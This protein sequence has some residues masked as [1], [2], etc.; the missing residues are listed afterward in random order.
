MKTNVEGLVVRVT[1]KEIWVQT[2]GGMV[3]CLLRGRFRQKGRDF[4][5][6]AGDRVEVAPPVSPGSPGAIEAVLPRRS[7]L[8]R[9]TGGRNAEERIIVANIDV[10]FVIE[11]IRSPD[12]SY[13][14]L[15]RVIVS[16]ENGH[17]DARICIN[18]IDLVDDR[19]DV[20]DVTT[21]YEPLGY[22]VVQTSAE[23]GEG[24][25]A[26]EDL[27]EGGIYAFVGRSGVGKSSLLNRIEPDLKLRVGTVAEKTGRGHH[28]TTYS[29]LFP[30]KGGYVADTPGMQTF[31]YPGTSTQ[32]LSEC[33]P[34]LRLR[35]DACRFQPCTHSHE[36]DCVVKEALEQGSI[37]P[38]R[39]QSY[40]SMLA[41]VKTREKNRY[42]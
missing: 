5:V 12:L 13:Q 15:D 25:D 3:P 37:A 22:P 30:L 2:G 21:V 11:S 17:I 28:T 23:T 38:S 27:I 4:Q 42:D 18:K 7:W 33:F 32:D 20:S 36:P 35:G 16:A 29:Q 10:L 39:Y 19:R 14:F 34:E 40:L 1:G 9:Y 6:A 26:V 24:M 8:S 31:G 41:E